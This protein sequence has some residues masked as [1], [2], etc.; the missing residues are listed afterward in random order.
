MATG[1]LSLGLQPQLRKPAAKGLS[2]ELVLGFFV[3]A[4]AH[5]PLRPIICDS[6]QNQIPR[7]LTYS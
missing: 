5:R 6:D 4:L 3:D 1:G 7:R 2:R